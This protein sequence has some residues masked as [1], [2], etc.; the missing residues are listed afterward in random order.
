M[1]VLLNFATFPSQIKA[2]H[3]MQTEWTRERMSARE[4]EK[5]MKKIKIRE[6]TF[7]WK[8][9]KVC[10]WLRNP[11]LFCSFP[12]PLDA[13]MLKFDTYGNLFDTFYY[14]SVSLLFTD[15]K[16]WWSVSM[17]THVATSPVFCYCWK[18]DL[19]DFKCILRVSK[20]YSLWHIL[21]FCWNALYNLI[22]SIM[23]I[24]D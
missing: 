8:L 4:T 5:E 7:E 22:D 20:P 19:M 23:M 11:L 1:R 16:L 18:L 12:F 13:M 15:E 21:I 6:R 14:V 24:E 9:L 10:H 17:A 3:R 2:F